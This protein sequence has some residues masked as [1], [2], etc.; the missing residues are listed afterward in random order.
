MEERNWREVE[1]NLEHPNANQR[2]REF[3]LGMNISESLCKDGTKTR[4][5]KEFFWGTAP[6]ISILGKLNVLRSVFGTLKYRLS[7]GRHFVLQ[8]KVQNMF[9]FVNGAC[10]CYTNM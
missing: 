1:G 6:A 10:S 4:L 3:L 2:E 9:N 7:I 8:H 5:R